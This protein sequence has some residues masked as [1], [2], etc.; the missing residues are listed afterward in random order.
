ML[1]FLFWLYV[2]WLIL[3]LGAQLSFYV[4][5]PEHL[6]TGHADI[7]MTGALRERLAISVMYLLG[8][9]FVVG[10]AALDHERA[11]RT[12]RRAGDRARQRRV[13][14]RV[15][16]AGARRGGRLD[17]PGPR[18]RARLRSRRSSTLSAT[19]CR[20]RGV[21]SRGRSQ[22]QTTSPRSADEA[23]RCESRQTARCSTSCATTRNAVVPLSRR[24][25]SSPRPGSSPCE[26]RRARPRRSRRRR[27]PGRCP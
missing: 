24:R 26:C 12:P 11:G 23:L 4:Q 1:L 20:I 7:P 14:P 5:H 13:G 2:S 18:P 15:T 10:R 16:R 22:P 8:Q 6:R 27:C 25:W 3:L 9:S 19:R 17:G 21:P